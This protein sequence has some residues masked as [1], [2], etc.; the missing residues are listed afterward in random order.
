MTVSAILWVRWV[1]CA[2]TIT[3]TIRTPSTLV[4]Y[5]GAFDFIVDVDVTAGSP[6]IAEH[7][8]RQLKPCLRSAQDRKPRRDP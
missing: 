1:G 6:T 2:S 3:S 5:L 4:P 7:L 8:F